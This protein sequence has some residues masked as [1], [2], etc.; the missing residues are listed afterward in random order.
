MSDSDT[1]ANKP[2]TTIL[3]ELRQRL[4]AADH[5][6]PAPYWLRAALCHLLWPSRFDA[7][8]Y[9]QRVLPGVTADLTDID[10]WYDVMVMPVPDPTAQVPAEEPV[11]EEPPETLDVS[12]LSAP[13]G[14]PIEGGVDGVYTGADD[15]EPGVDY[16]DEWFETVAVATEAG[17]VADHDDEEAA[18]IRRISTLTAE[19]QRLRDELAT[20]AEQSVPPADLVGRGPVPSEA[21]S[22]APKSRKID[23]MEAGRWFPDLRP[24][25]D[26][27]APHPRDRQGA[28]PATFDYYKAKGAA[29]MAKPLSAGQ[30]HG[31][32]GRARG[33]TQ[34]AMYQGWP[35][36]AP[37]FVVPAGTPPAPDPIGPVSVV[38][39]PS[40]PDV[41]LHVVLDP[42]TKRAGRTLSVA[43]VSLLDERFRLAEERRQDRE[44]RQRAHMRDAEEM[45][46]A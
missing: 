19:I 1:S 38:Q 28:M 23:T 11:A 27:W 30:V 22:P 2:E 20:L 18:E 10:E 29:F 37:V 25:S 13:L 21:A 44:A 14:E 3:G 33:L 34:R 4:E 42:E 9:L 45:A 39:A 41:E 6:L 7:P 35:L 43:G 40:H 5:S 26:R 16:D 17:P 12:T 15:F 46:N 36:E 32:A 24:L 8:V 31:E